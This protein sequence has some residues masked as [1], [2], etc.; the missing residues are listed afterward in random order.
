MSWAAVTKLEVLPLGGKYC[1]AV[2]TTGFGL[3]Y[4]VQVTDASRQQ[5]AEEL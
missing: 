1:C 3:C 5:D 2:D 4:L